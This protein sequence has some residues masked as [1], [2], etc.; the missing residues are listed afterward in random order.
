MNPLWGRE[1]YGKTQRSPPVPFRPQSWFP[2]FETDQWRE[3]GR[4]F[5]A[6]EG[7]NPYDYSF[8]VLDRRR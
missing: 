1:D 5:F 4:E 8:V 2:E 3:A 6:A 7:P